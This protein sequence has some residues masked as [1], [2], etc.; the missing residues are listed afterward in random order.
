MDSV[1]EKLRLENRYYTNFTA[2]L[3]YLWDF[4]GQSF[5]K[6]S[7]GRGRLFL[8]L[9][10]SHPC[11]YMDLTGFA[12]IFS[13]QERNRPIICNKS[14][15]FLQFSLSDIKKDNWKEHSNKRVQIMFQLSG[16]NEWSFS[17]RSCNKRCFIE[18][19]WQKV[20]HSLC[21]ILIYTW[22]QCWGTCWELKAFLEILVLIVTSQLEDYV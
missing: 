8:L 7:K 18:D 17:D 5:L 20:G 10:V 9:S 1:M 2:C 4:A 21:Q 6:L 12:L 13:I 11:N 14:A 19:G 3:I 22:T 15:S 16:E